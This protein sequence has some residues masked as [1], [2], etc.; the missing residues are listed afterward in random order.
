MNPD[1]LKINKIRRL[2]NLAMEMQKAVKMSM[3]GPSDDL[4]PVNVKIGINIGPLST[5]II[6]FQ[7]I[8][9]LQNNEN[10]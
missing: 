5:G 10:K 6:G 3:Y 2:I 1:T 9:N 8:I 7:Y 4:K